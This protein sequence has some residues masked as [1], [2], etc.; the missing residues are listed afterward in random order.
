[1]DDDENLSRSYLYTKCSN[2]NTISQDQLNTSL[3]N[4][5]S[6]NADQ[7]SMLMTGTNNY[8]NMIGN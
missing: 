3:F 2:L 7:S 5:T 6:H 4:K 1:M 8:L